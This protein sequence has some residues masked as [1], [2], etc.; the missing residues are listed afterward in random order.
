MAAARAAAQDLFNVRPKPDVQ[1]PVGLVQHNY[2]QIIQTQRVAANVIEHAPGSAN[3]DFGPAFQLFDLSANRL[4]A[5][6]GHRVHFA[7]VGQL[8]DFLAHLHGQLARRHQHQ[9]LYGAAAFVRL[10]PFQNR[11]D[12]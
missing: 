8:D 7:A 11:D 5:I 12:E 1:H 6:H 2:P 3:D 9:C 10:Q 4:A